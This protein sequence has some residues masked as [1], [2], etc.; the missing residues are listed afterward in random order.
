MRNAK[1]LGSCDASP[2]DETRL[3]ESHEVDLT[4]GT[5]ADGREED[6][7]VEMYMYKYTYSQIH[8]SALF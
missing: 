8:D 2:V 7:Q 3:V 4:T 6:L 1:D 5:A